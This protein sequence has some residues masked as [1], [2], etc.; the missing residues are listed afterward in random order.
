MF[1][2]FIDTATPEIDTYLP[3]LSLHDALPIS[4]Y[5]TTLGTVTVYN[6]SQP[7]SLALDDFSASPH[8][9][10][11]LAWHIP[12]STAA[13][14]PILLKFEPSATLAAPVRFYLQSTAEYRSE[15]PTSELQSLMRIS[16]A[17]FCL[18]TTHT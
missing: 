12:A 13:S 10:G 1:L 4:I 18:Q 8:G 2:F 17:V 3:T 16:S 15:E 9:H 11:R 5:P 7:H 14:T 6:G